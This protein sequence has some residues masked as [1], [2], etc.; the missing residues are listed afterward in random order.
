MTINKLYDGVNGESVYRGALSNEAHTVAANFNGAVD[1]AELAKATSDANLWYGTNKVANTDYTITSSLMSGNGTLTLDNANKRVTAASITTDTVVW[2]IHFMIDDKEVDVCDFTVTKAKGG[3]I[4]N[5]QISIYCMST[6]TPNRP[7]LTYRPSSA[8]AY[9]NGYTWYPDPTYS[10]SYSTWESKGAL[11]PNQNGTIVVDSNTGYRWTSPV[12]ISGKDGAQGPQGDRGPAGYDGANGSDGMDGPGLNYRGD[13]TSGKAYGWSSSNAGN[14]RDVVKDGSYY[15]MWNSYY[16]G[17]VPT[18]TSSNR[19]SSSYT[20]VDGSSGRYWTRFGSSFESIATGL[21]YANKATIA[22]WDFF[23]YK[24]V[25]ANGSVVIN[26]N[27][28][29][30]NAESG[31]STDIVFAA[32]NGDYPAWNGSSLNNNA[33]LKIHNSG[34]ITVG[35]GVDNSRAGMTGSNAEDQVRFWAGTT[36]DK[37]RTAP[38][39]VHDNGSMVATNGTFTGSVTCNNLT[40]TN[41]AQ[42]FGPGVVCICD[43]DGYTIRQQYSVGGKTIS[44]ITNSNDKSIK[45]THNI[46]H[47]NYSVIAV[48]SGRRSTSGFLGSAGCYDMSAYACTITFKDT[49]NNWHRPG[50]K[51]NDT[52]DIIILSHQ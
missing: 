6:S 25:A 46:G 12:K 1:S 39:R 34:V 8:G 52:V 51:G 30:E 21:L 37:R 43:Y 14:V 47:T 29:R 20:T 50:L 3:A 31:T 9:N 2:R 13:W 41:R 10:T 42:W 11:D 18:A 16:R 35:A 15:Y 33:P 45:L 27:S 24:I 19:P 7:T 26:G 28:V 36:Y 38:F 48:G 22:G 23:K 4:G 49:D 17:S 40:V 44:K 32:G 5:Q